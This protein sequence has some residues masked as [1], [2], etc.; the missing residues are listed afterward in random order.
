MAERVYLARLDD[1]QDWPEEIDLKSRYFS[2]S[3]AMD[4]REIEAEAVIAFA[5][6]LLDQGLAAVD[7]FGPDC[8]RVERLFDDAIVA[9]D[10]RGIHHPD[11]MTTVETTSASEGDIDEALWYAAHVLFPPGEYGREVP[12][13]LVMVV[14]HPEWADHLEARLMAFDQFD[15]DM[16]ERDA[17]RSGKKGEERP[18]SEAMAGVPLLAGSAP[19]PRQGRRPCRRRPQVCTI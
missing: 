15:R 11:T 17:R 7:V 5:D 6:R 9:R 19:Q 13:L 14:G 3:L 8:E 10:L 16:D 2:L 1:L 4:A 12:S 18:P